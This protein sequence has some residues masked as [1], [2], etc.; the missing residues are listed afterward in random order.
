MQSGAY[1]GAR[2]GVMGRGKGNALRGGRAGRGPADPSGCDAAA[3][4]TRLQRGRARPAHGRR[5]IRRPARPTTDLR[6]GRRR[7]PR[8]GPRPAGAAGH[9]HG[10]GPAHPGRPALPGTGAGPLA[11]PAVARRRPARHPDR[12][13]PRRPGRDPPA[14]SAAGAGKCREPAGGGL[15]PCGSRPRDFVATSGTCL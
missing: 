13:D 11:L 12:A 9:R 6:A 5:V 2:P 14:L 7:R 4:R 3:H 8:P 1:R 15:L 10:R